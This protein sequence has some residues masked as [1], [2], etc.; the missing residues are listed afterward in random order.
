MLLLFAATAADFPVPV[1]LPAVASGA[2]AAATPSPL[3]LLPLVRQLRRHLSHFS[4][5]LGGVEV[6][7]RT[8]LP[9]SETVFQ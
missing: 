7:G 6:L 2:A 9:P 5:F 8:R 4:K 3:P 1:P